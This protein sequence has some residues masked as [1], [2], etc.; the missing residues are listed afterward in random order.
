MAKY[1][2][3]TVKGQGVLR[4]EVTKLPGH[5]L[6]T[7]RLVFDEF[8]LAD[9]DNEPY[10]KDRG[11][12]L[13]TTVQDTG[14]ADSGRN[15]KVVATL[16]ESFIPDL[17][18]YNEYIPSG[19]GLKIQQ[20]TGRLL[21]QFEFSKDQEK[22][23]GEIKLAL[24]D[25][26]AHYRSVTVSGH[27][28]LH[29]V[30]KRGDLESKSFDAAGTRLDLS[31]I[32]VTKDQWEITSDWW[33]KVT[34]G[35]TALEFK[36]KPA[37]TGDIEIRMSDTKPILAIFQEQ[38]DLPEWIQQDL[39]LENL[40]AEAVLALSNRILNIEDFE[41]NSGSWTML[42]DLVM[43]P[44]GREGILYIKRGPLGF[45]IEHL[46]EQRKVKLLHGREWFDERRAHFRANNKSNVGE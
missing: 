21:S 13:V 27:A 3:Y 22:V 6:T 33:G 30:I 18:H 10:L 46:G 4:G 45:V 15:L 37:A 36:P 20:G 5:S 19:I 35:N 2:H 24:T 11:F 14:L 39:V 42:G 17:T 8:T 32:T 43:S 23:A 28:D 12:E 1:L 9:D 34:F 31:D 38:E 25:I 29:T 16:P 7:L 41:L 40:R 26:V 44:D